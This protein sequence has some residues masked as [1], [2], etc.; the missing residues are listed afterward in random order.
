VRKLKW[1]YSLIE[2]TVTLC[3]GLL[4]SVQRDGDLDRAE[5]NV[6]RQPESVI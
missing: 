4:G 2:S 6:W 1:D 3:V 5:L